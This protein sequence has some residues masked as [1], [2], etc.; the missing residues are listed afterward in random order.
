MRPT[1]QPSRCS[2]AGS[3]ARRR[4]L[5]GAWLASVA[6]AAVPGTALSGHKLLL[7]HGEE[8]QIEFAHDKPVNADRHLT[9]SISYGA[10]F[11]L[12]TESEINFDLDAGE[13]D[14]F[15]EAEPKL[16]AALAYE[17]NARLR[18]YTE[19]TLSEK[20][21]IES[22]DEEESDLKLNLK[23]AYVT[24]RDIVDGI[25]LSVGRQYMGDEREWLFDEELDG[26]TAYWRNEDLALEVAYRRQGLA[27]R[28]LLREEERKR[29][30]FFI[31]RGFHAI[32]DDS[33]V[34]PFVIYQDGHEGRTDEDL[35]FLG[36]QSYAELDNDIAVWADG[37][38]VLGEA[39][40]RDVRGF[41]FDVG[42]VKTFRDLPLKP[43]LTAAAAFGSG[44]DGSGTDTA[45]RQTSVQDNSDKFGGVTSL[46]YYGEVLD[47][48][49]SNLGIL[50]LGAGFRPSRRTSIDFV[51]HRYVQ[52]RLQD[53][54]R[55][56]AI[57]EDPDG[58]HRDIGNGFDIVFGFEEIE[59]LNVELVGGV[60]LPGSAFEADDPAFFGA[61]TFLYKF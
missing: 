47:P 13:D 50:T 58:E 1:L 16:Q 4:A 45:F 18:V 26:V 23:Q 60:F 61:V 46:Q 8:P 11:E 56:V 49:L 34:S 39:R 14:D 55:D 44:D 15:H 37:A 59:N 19:F 42:L 17:P 21:I 30:D 32:D 29:P 10:R 51:Y 36:V 3:K 31:A 5:L 7:N 41:G 52:P 53:D 54:F 2:T 43:Y 35:L 28:D 9:E 48:E 25:T 38:T 40:G 33:R 20:L 22:P 24:L 12:E 27:R 6:L 57:D